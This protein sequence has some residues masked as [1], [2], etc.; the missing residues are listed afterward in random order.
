MVTISF[1]IT[2]AEGHRHKASF[3]ASRH[4]DWSKEDFPRVVEVFCADVL[5]THQYIV[6]RVSASTD[7]EARHECQSQVDDGLFEGCRYGKIEELNL[8]TLSE[9]IQRLNAAYSSECEEIADSLEEEGYPS[10]GNN[11]ELRC[12]SL[13]E[14]CY[15]AELSELYACAA[16]VRGVSF[17]DLTEEVGLG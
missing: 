2:G 12:S 11:Y 1:K 17:Y 6:L 13:Y 4:F 3:G 10:H 9:S 5:E 8:A 7:A 15:S 16:I 14:N